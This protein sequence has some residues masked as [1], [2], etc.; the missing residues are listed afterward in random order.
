MNNLRKQT[1]PW[2]ATDA[3]NKAYFQRTDDYLHNRT[4]HRIKSTEGREKGT[5]RGAPRQYGQSRL[6]PSVPRQIQSKLI[7]KEKTLSMLGH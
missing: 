7:R 5:E 1:A 4:L 2:T 3:I 6:S